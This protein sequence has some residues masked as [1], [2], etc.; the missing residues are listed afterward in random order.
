LELLG[1]P[2]VLVQCCLKFLVGVVKSARQ[3]NDSGRL[4]SR[5]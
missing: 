1:G 2:L 4:E 3:L 5:N